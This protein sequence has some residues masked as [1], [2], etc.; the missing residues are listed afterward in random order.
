MN[1]FKFLRFV[2][3]TEIITV[4]SQDQWKGYVNWT[5]SRQFWQVTHEENHHQVYQDMCQQMKCVYGKKCVYMEMSMEKR[6]ISIESQHMYSTASWK[7]GSHRRKM[8]HQILLTVL[9]CQHMTILQWKM[10]CG[11]TINKLRS[12]D[13]HFHWIV[14]RAI[15]TI[16]FKESD[17]WLTH[18]VKTKHNATFTNNGHS[19]K[20]NKTKHLNIIKYNSYIIIKQF[21]PNQ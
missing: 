7:T 6:R 17:Q 18:L 1:S 3:A 4:K 2:P 19:V 9:L 16:N 10:F 11:L 5:N 21:R 14:L 20:Q 8:Y 15:E 12:Q 13:K